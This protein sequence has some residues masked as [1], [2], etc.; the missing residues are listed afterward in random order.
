VAWAFLARTLVGTVIAAW[1]LARHAGVRFAQLS[2][3]VFHPLV[4][5]L[6]VLLAVTMLRER[7][8]GLPV[9][10]QAACLIA[11]GIVAYALVMAPLLLRRRQQILATLSTRAG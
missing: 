5:A 10:Q 1:L 11:V 4:G 9:A 8:A 6:A 7:L 2:H 3:A